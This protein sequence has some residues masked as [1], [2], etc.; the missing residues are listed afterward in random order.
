[1][2]YIGNIVTKNK[3]DVSEFFLVTDDITNIDNTNPTLI[4]GWNL[5]KEY[6]PNQ[7]ILHSSISENITWTFSKREKRYRYEIDIVDFVQKC[8]EK[9]LTN[10]NYKF[11]N[12]LTASP[13]K[14]KSFI[15]FVNRG[16]CYIYHN[17]RFAYIYS[18]NSKMT[19]GISLVDLKYVGIKIKSFLSMLNVEGNN[20]IINNLD[21]LSEESLSIIKGNV[22]VAAYL[23]YLKNPT[24]YS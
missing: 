14:R 10:I 2:K 5:V 1:M 18:P 8:T 6:Y 3:V 21:F 4:V 9:L 11:F 13:E 20:S 17:S 23:H 12:Y 19:I 24:I 15:Q 7:D 16:N 22:K